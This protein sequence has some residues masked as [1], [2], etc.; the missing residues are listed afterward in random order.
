MSFA[1]DCT[2]VCHWLPRFLRKRI[3]G[4]DLVKPAARCLVHGETEAAG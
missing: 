4:W 2:S 1:D 3:T